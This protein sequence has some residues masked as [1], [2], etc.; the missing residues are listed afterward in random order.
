MILEGREEVGDA[1]FLEQGAEH[2]E[3]IG[4]HLHARRRELAASTEIKQVAAAGHMPV[5]PGMQLPVFKILAVL[6]VDHPDAAGSQPRQQ[7]KSSRRRRR[8]QTR[9]KFSRVLVASFLLQIASK[10]PRA[11]QASKASA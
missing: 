6:E 9:T 10:S 2:I 3:I 5:Q 8:P 11:L 4:N 1:G 7:Q